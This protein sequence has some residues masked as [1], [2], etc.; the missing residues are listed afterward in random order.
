MAPIKLVRDDSCPFVLPEI[1][2]VP[3]VGLKLKGLS[4]A[5]EWQG[6][7]VPS[8]SATSVCLPDLLFV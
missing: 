7:V 5:L 8:M 6:G 1:S 4:Y 2:T 3:Q